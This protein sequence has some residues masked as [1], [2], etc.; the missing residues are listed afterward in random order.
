MWI[1]NNDVCSYCVIG[2]LVVKLVVGDVMGECLVIEKVILL[3]MVVIE[4]KGVDEFVLK[5]V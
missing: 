3:I 4:I 2:D 1:V 5:L